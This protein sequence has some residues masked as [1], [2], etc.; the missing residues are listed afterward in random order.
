MLRPTG[1]S[2]KIQSIKSSQYIGSIGSI[3]SI[4][5]IG[6]YRKHT[7]CKMNKLDRENAKG[8]GAEKST[9]WWRNTIEIAEFDKHMICSPG[10][11]G[12]FALGT[13]SKTYLKDAVFERK[14][15]RKKNIAKITKSKNVKFDT[16]IKNRIGTRY[17]FV[18]IKTFW[19]TSIQFVW[20]LSPSDQFCFSST[21]NT[22]LIGHCHIYILY[23]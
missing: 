21:F 9:F 10:L 3:G 5:Y 16:K 11:C 8:V 1:Q 15:F 22:T 13:L 17:Y 6:S 2:D 7:S 14:V 23:K 12:H 20:I 18:S 4:G 19:Y